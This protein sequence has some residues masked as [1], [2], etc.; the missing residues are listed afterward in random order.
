MNIP[1]DPE[2]I[3]E[4]LWVLNKIEKERQVHLD[5]DIITY[6]IP[7]RTISANGVPSL[8]HEYS[9]I[10]TLKKE[11]LIEAAEANESYYDPDSFDPYERLMKVRVIKII[12]IE[13]FKKLRETLLLKNAN[14]ETEII[15]APIEK[16]RKDVI[17]FLTS[18]YDGK[19]ENIKISSSVLRE[20]GFGDDFWERI[21]PQLEREGILKS[22]NK[23]MF[24]TEYTNQP[25][26]DA[27]WKDLMRLNEFNLKEGLF[28]PF[29][30]HD[31]HSIKILEEIEELKKKESELEKE[32][33]SIPIL[34]TF[35]VDGKK[36]T[37]ALETNIKG[38]KEKIILQKTNNKRIQLPN[39]PADLRWEEIS[40]QFLNGH[41]VI[42]KVRNETLQATYET[43]GFQDEKRKLPNSQWGL[44]EMLAQKNGEISWGNNSNLSLKKINSI[45][46]QKQLLSDALKAYFR[47][48]DDE[49]FFNYKVEKAYKIK[50]ALTPESK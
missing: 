3:S 35:V 20:N 45:K 33:K 41:E 42:I 5:D 7:E 21:C 31:K 19:N 29:F 44:L 15:Y 23:F 27:I 1:T 6:P 28:D 9:I 34:H 16:R 43:M 18:Y 49:P 40:I 8:D 2:I 48:Y 47:I 46:K 12:D 17:E 4:F 50:I 38:F 10:K 24:P 26:A 36:L 25:R 14:K 11:G 39:L 22:Y 30:I 37:E 32:L 13:G